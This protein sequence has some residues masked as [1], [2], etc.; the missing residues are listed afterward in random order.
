MPSCGWAGLGKRGQGPGVKRKGKIKRRWAGLA[1]G[2]WAEVDGLQPR[3]RFD[4]F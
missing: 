1:G 3:D 2:R 4:Y